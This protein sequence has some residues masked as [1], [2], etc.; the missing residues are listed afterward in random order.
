MPRQG[1]NLI[2]EAAT[3]LSTKQKIGIGAG[4]IILAAVLAVLNSSGNIIWNNFSAQNDMPVCGERATL[5]GNYSPTDTLTDV[6][7]RIH[8]ANGVSYIP[9]TAVFSGG[10][11]LVNEDVTDPRVPVF[12]L[13]DATGPVSFLMDRTASCEAYNTQLSGGQLVD[14]AK[15][16]SEGSQVGSDEISNAYSLQYA[17][18]GVSDVQTTPNIAEVGDTVTREITI[19]NGNFGA[20]SSFYF[21]ENISPGDLDFFDFII[22]PTTTN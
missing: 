3:H 10:A 6:N 1:P 18:L 2:S 16:F 7:M 13:T 4:T 14:T 20:R 9:G 8:L 12:T 22:N 5:T 15:V 17:T 21:G 19:T 11:T